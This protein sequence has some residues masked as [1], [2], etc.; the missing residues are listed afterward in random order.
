MSF[1]RSKDFE[2]MK[3]GKSAI[4]PWLSCQYTKNTLMDKPCPELNIHFIDSCIQWSVVLYLGTWPIT[5]GS[6]LGHCKKD[7]ETDPFFFY[8]FRSQVLSTWLGLKSSTFSL[9]AIE[10]SYSFENWSSIK[11]SR[12]RLPGCAAAPVQDTCL[13][14]HKWDVKSL[15]WFCNDFPFLPVQLF[16]FLDISIITVF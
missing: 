12:I 16:T 1:Y 8:L 2:A 15:W 14:I 10:S 5:V 3:A 11:Y 13:G 4:Q 7:L 9:W 6:K